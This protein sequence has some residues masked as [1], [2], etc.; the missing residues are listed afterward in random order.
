MRRLLALVALV[1][2]GSVGNAQA[3]TITFEDLPL[4][5]AGIGGDRT[6]GGFFFDTATDHSHIVQAAATWGTGNGTHFM[7]IDD[8]GGTHPPPTNPLTFSPV[9]GALFTLT[10]I[11]ISEAGGIGPINLSTTARKIKVTGNQFGGGIVT[12][13]LNLDLNFID[14]QPANYFQTFTFDP[15]VW[16]NLSSV[17]LQGTGALC[18]GN[19]PGMGGNYY[20]IDNIV[21][22]AAVPEPGT[23]T[24]LGLGSAY[25]IRRR[26]SNCR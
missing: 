3:T 16:G 19:I 26:R 12:A 22:T 10:S 23:L 2:A 17:V 4:D 13:T 1:L 25:L 14:N 18:C 21:V 15:A 8:V 24:L 9:S 6:S 20:G 5:E 7:M 11:D